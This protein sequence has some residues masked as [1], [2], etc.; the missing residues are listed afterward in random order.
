MIALKQTNKKKTVSR[1]FTNQNVPYLIWHESLL[2]SVLNYDQSYSWLCNLLP[3]KSGS[4]RLGD[5]SKSV[6]I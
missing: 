6:A 1:S 5:F 4:E 3:L 2:G